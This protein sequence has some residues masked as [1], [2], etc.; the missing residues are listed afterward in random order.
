MWCLTLA[1]ALHKQE[2]RISFILRN[3]RGNMVR[4]TERKGYQL[5]T[6][7]NPA[8]VQESQSPGDVSENL[9]LSNWLGTT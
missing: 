2:R 8:K 9:I 7:G 4:F 3:H 1:F 5:L 6:L